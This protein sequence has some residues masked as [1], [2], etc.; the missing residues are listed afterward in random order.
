M[1]RVLKLRA[2]DY[3]EYQ[4]KNR[5]ESEETFFSDLLENVSV[6]FCKSKSLDYFE[7][8]IQK[9]SPINDVTEEDWET[10]LIEL[11]R[12]GIFIIYPDI[13]EVDNVNLNQEWMKGTGVFNC[14]LRNYLF[15]KTEVAKVLNVQLEYYILRFK[16]GVYTK[17]IVS[18]KSKIIS[19]LSENDVVEYSNKDRNIIKKE[20]VE[21]ERPEFKA[22]LCIKRGRSGEIISGEFQLE[23]GK[24]IKLTKERVITVKAIAE[25]EGITFKH[26]KENYLKGEEPHWMNSFSTMFKTK[27]KG[28][29]HKILELVDHHKNSKGTFLR[30]KGTIKI[31]ES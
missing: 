5:C 27:T 30:F 29:T 18:Y 28:T 1:N 15:Y 6:D 9:R 22:R 19:K 20:D 2:L 26:I 21:V 8:K 25:S 11:E 12:E 10:I 31:E 7:L 4:L 16:K 3:V 24:E 13:E 17:K 14:G 23:S